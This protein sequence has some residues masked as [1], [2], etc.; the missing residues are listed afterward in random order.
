MTKQGR[1]R[2]HGCRNG[3][4]CSCGPGADKHG[5]NLL[6]EGTGIGNCEIFNKTIS[7]LIK[8]VMFE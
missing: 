7:L 5:D 3:G 6:F 2:R 1:Y 4:D 8:N